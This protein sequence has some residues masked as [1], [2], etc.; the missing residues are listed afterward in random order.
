MTHIVLSPGSRNAPLT[1]SFSR[2]PKL[3]L[4][5]ILDE[6]TAGFIA[7]G[8][9]Q[10]T[11]KPVGICCTSG[12]ALMNYGPAIAEAYY[13]QIPLVIFS[14]DRPPEWIDQRDGQTIN[15]T[16]PLSNFVKSFHQL[17]TSYQHPDE[18]WEINRKI[19][20]SINEALQKPQGPTH[21][22]VPF[23]EPFYPDKD[24]KIRF[25][26]E[27]RIIEN[28]VN[29]EYNYDSLLDEWNNY[30]KKL[31]I[32]GQN[33]ENE[34]L[35]EKLL[36][37][38]N[39]HSIPV[40]TDIISNQSSDLL[41]QYHDLFLA[42]KNK[43]LLENFKPDLVISTGKSIISKNL[44]SFLRVYKPKDIWHF[45]SAHVTADTFQSLTK[46]I[47]GHLSDFLQELD[48]FNPQD[49]FKKQVQSNF[50]QNWTVLNKN[51]REKL[52][53]AL[54]KSPFCEFTAMH[55]VL[56]SIPGNTDL[57]IGNSMPVRY[58][59]FIHQLNK[60]VT[61]FANRGTSGIDGTNA[62]AVG[63]AL[64]SKRDVVLITGDLS[65]FYDRNA[66]FH[67]HDIH[68][69]KIIV[70]NN[71]GGG[72]F[73]LIN[74]PS[75]LAELTTHFETR[76]HHSAKFTAAEYG[77]DYFAA[78]DSKGLKKGLHELFKDS[79]EKKLLEIFTDPKQNQEVYNQIKNIIHE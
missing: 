76:H 12:T 30:E 72:I 56:S 20:T 79:K 70:V 61:V 27:V 13:Q 8:I 66:F 34:H 62:T 69:L 67:P 6:R 25:S 42:I 58:A 11:K 33:E 23:R 51:T 68:N 19:N 18:Q 75:Q 45:D 53:K 52:F 54:D 50:H 41:I 26:K 15:Q 4:I 74:G 63:H 5:T 36:N 57:H 77:F 2:H 40:I 46:L 37:L 21:I 48:S 14:A 39:Q 44:K 59:N 1:V 73:R 7:L 32:I 71:L 60:N 38:S 16:N 22:N 28:T 29:I 35:K 24:Q 49:D 55:Q 65:F 64:T 78:K 9:A 47:Q 31:I 17:P 43:E 3:E 10:K